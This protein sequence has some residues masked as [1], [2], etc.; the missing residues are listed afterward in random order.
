M[1]RHPISSLPP[2]TKVADNITIGVANQGI[3]GFVSIEEIPMTNVCIAQN[4]NR[5]Q[6]LFFLQ[7]NTYFTIAFGDL[8]GNT[9]IAAIVGPKPPIRWISVNTPCEEFTIFKCVSKANPHQ[10]MYVMAKVIVRYVKSFFLSILPLPKV[11]L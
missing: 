9:K 3:A 1:P 4:N 5:Y 2:P 7:E 6:M 10:Q 11:P 8:S